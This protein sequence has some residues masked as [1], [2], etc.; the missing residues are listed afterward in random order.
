M[1]TR[2]FNSLLPETTDNEIDLLGKLLTA[3]LANSESLVG[4]NVGR[5]AQTAS[6]NKGYTNRMKIVIPKA[7]RNL[8]FW[9]AGFKEGSYPNS[10]A[11]F[12]N[13]YTVKMAV[14]TASGGS[15]SGTI[16]PVSFNGVRTGSVD[17]GAWLASDPLGISCAAGDVLFLRVYTTASGSFVPVNRYIGGVFLS[18]GEGVTVPPADSADSGTITAFDWGSACCPVAITGQTSDRQGVLVCGT[19]ITAYSNDRAFDSPM[20]GWIARGLSSVRG[21]VNVALGGETVQQLITPQRIYPRLIFARYCRAAIID[22]GTNDLY[23]AGRT[24]AQLKADYQTLVTMLRD[25]G[26]PKIYGCKIIPRNTSTDGWET[27]GN[28]TVTAYETDRLGFNTWLDSAES[29][30]DQVIDVLSSIESSAGIFKANAATVNRTT[31]AG[32]TTTSVVDTGGMT[33]SAYA[34]KVIKFGTSY[35]MILSNTAT[36]LTLQTALGSTPGT[37]VA[38]SILDVYTNDGVHPTAVGHRAMATA[39]ASVFAAI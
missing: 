17:P 28:Q 24:L 12:D 33:P 27:T 26:I 14:E 16:I 38:Y 10:L 19:S 39:A 22:S 23:V 20:H 25:A 30:V 4:T 6:T 11:L 21:H 2:T 5:L 7:C 9:F 15:P 3:S 29:P 31:G 13:N 32:S 8:R 34:G 18:N 1:S 36:T 35:S 37:G